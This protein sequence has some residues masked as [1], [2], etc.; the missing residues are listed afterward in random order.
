MM[1]ERPMSGGWRSAPL[2]IFGIAVLIL[3]GGIGVIVQNEGTYDRARAEQTR[4]LADVLAASATAAVDFDDPAAAQQAVNAFR[5]NDQI[6][7]IGIYGRDG[8]VVAGYERSRT[9]LPATIALIPEPPPHM[10]RVTAPV[11]RSGQQIGT[12]YMEIEREAAS[13]R[14]ARYLLLIG[15]LILAALVVAAL[16]F[17]QHQLRRANRELGR[18]AEA[19]AESNELLQEQM[20]E[21][22][23]AEEQLRQSQK[24]QALGQLT[25]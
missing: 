9:P 7:W 4:G 18:R 1:G 21:R 17:A 22:A 6:R 10:I 19:L 12:V 3:L 24:M 20:E 15:L 13:R 16:G 14:V 8:K 11:E 23:K 25:G 5:V 2:A